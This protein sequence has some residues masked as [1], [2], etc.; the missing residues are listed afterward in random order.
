MRDRTASRNYSAEREE[1]RREH[2]RH[3]EWGLRRRHAEKLQRI[4]QRDSG[5]PSKPATAGVQGPR[6]A[7]SPRRPAPPIPAAV[8]PGPRR[9]VTRPATPPTGRFGARRATPAPRPGPLTSLQLTSPLE[10]GGSSQAALPQAVARQSGVAVVGAEADVILDLDGLS[11]AVVPQ[12]ALSL[13][14]SLSLPLPLPL[15]LL[16][17]LSEPEPEPTLPL[18]LGGSS[19]AVVPQVVVRQSGVAVAGAGAGA[20]VV[21]GL[22]WVVAGGVAAGGGAAAD[23]GLGLG[24]G[25][26]V[27]VGGAA[28]GGVG[29]GAAAAR[30][31][32][33]VVFGFGPVVAVGAASARGSATGIGICAVGLLSVGRAAVGVCASVGGDEPVGVTTVGVGN[34]SGA[35]FPGRAAPVCVAMPSAS[36]T[37]GGCSIDEL[38]AWFR[39]GALVRTTEPICRGSSM[40]TCGFGRWRGVGRFA[41]GLSL[42]W[43]VS[44][45]GGL[46]FISAWEEMFRRRVGARLRMRSDRLR[47]RIRLVA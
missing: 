47:M 31:A 9:A 39:G 34:C 11:Q 8:L 12:P 7:D 21:L 10:L 33:D 17:P 18:G 46:R 44:G 15:P 28:V 25:S 37:A 5:P 36:P 20:D 29:V 41:V 6:A 40:S 23:V 30:A 16:L 22:G 43:V 13:S 38:A 27:A 4:R 14:L 45:R 35:G 19:Q 32:A 3:R 24:L 2:E 26:A 42:I 1:F